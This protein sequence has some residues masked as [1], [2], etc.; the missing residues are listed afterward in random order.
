MEAEAKL[1][2][3]AA[4]NTEMGGAFQ[5]AVRQTVGSSWAVVVRREMVST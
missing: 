4:L 5:R 3:A 2:L 1:R